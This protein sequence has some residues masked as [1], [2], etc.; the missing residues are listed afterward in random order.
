MKNRVIFSML[1]LAVLL[2]VSAWAEAKV[3]ITE[4]NDKL[5]LINYGGELNF[6]HVA[7]KGEDGVLLVDSAYGGVGDKLREKLAEYGEVKYLINSHAHWDHIAENCS[8]AETAVIIA[9]EDAR[10]NFSRR[11]HYL[12]PID[13]KC[14]AHVTFRDALTVNFNS[15]RIE[16]K[17][18]PAGH[19]DGDVVTWFPEFKIAYIADL[20]NHTNLYVVD[21]NMK[22]SLDGF[23]KSLRYLLSDFPDDTTFIQTHGPRYTKEDVRK[24]LNK[25]ESAVRLIRKDIR[26]GEDRDTITKHLESKFPSMKHGDELIKIVMIT[27]DIPVPESIAKV[28]TKVMMEK[29]IDAALESYNKIKKE[30]NGGHIIS[31]WELNVLGYELLRRDMIDE[32]LAVFRLNAAEY[33]ES[34]N[35]YDSL[36]EA[37]LAS[38]EPEAAFKNYMEAY[39][40]DNTNLNAKKQADLIREKLKE[41]GR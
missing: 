13:L 18:T 41:S 9:H 28:M 6:N 32:A 40:R 11:F 5:L 10:K 30:N 36:G 12:K 14:K 4:L 15:I 3:Q 21:L 38:G 23:I 39:R 25:F 20:I 17:H 7:V 31:E 37:C 34:S 27:D 24:Y 22:G 1:L 33:P 2:S 35:V 16:L 8:F 19:T 26:E 29:G